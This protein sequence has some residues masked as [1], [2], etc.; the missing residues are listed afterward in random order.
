M[1]QLLIG[2]VLTFHTFNIIGILHNVFQT[3]LISER[4]KGGLGWGLVGWLLGW[5]F[6]G[7]R[8]VPDGAGA[9]GAEGGQCWRGELFSFLLL[10]LCVCN[11]LL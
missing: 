6:V 2:W 1:L 11:A 4:E 10:Y 7:C 9:G 8:D 3:A 5:G